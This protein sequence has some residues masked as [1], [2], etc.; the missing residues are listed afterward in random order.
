MKAVWILVFFLTMMMPTL[1]SATEPS[2]ETSVEAA[3]VVSKTNEVVTCQ[4]LAVAA[5]ESHAATIRDLRQIKRDLAQLQQKLDEPGMGQI[6]SGIGYIFGLFGVAAFVA[7]RKK[8][9]S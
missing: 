2:G 4:D 3:V 9:E 5:R 7:S 1:S 8:R 6:F